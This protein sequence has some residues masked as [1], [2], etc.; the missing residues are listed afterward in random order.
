MRKAMLLVV[1]ALAT[2]ILALAMAPNSVFYR[3]RRPTR[4][5]RLVIRT[6]A[7]WSGLGLPPRF[8]VALEVPRR[9][10]A[11]VQSIPMVVANVDGERYFVSML[12]ERSDWVRNVR[13]ANG[14]AVIRSG[15]RTPVVLEEV[16]V[17]ERAPVLKAYVKRAFGARPHFV[18]GPD[19]PL[20]EFEAVAGEYP[21]FRVR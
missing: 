3:D 14:M 17:E 21:V 1:L 9:S 10:G 11:G 8:Q 6:Q 15:G 2:T 12:G 16:P 20:A 18:P 5:G 13:A 19:S 4:L 7:V